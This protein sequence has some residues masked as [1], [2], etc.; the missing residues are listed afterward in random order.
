MVLPAQLNPP[1]FV[2]PLQQV[3][4]TT[5]QVAEGIASS[6]H[7]SLEEKI[8]QF[9]FAEEERTP[10]RPVEILDFEIESDRLS[11]AHQPS[12]AT[13]FFETSSKE[14]K[15]MD[16]EKRPSLRGL[17]ANR[18][19]GA[20]PPEAPKAQASAN[21]PPP[22]PVD[23]GPRVNPDPKKKIPLQELEEGEMPPQKG[24]K[25]QRTKG[26]RDK[27]SKSVESRDDVETH[28]QQC[29]WAPVVEMDEAPIPY[30]STIWES[31]RGHSMYLAQALEQP[32]LL[33]KDMDALRRMRQLDLFM[34]LKRDPAMVS[35][36]SCASQL[37]PLLFTCI[38]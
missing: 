12:Q 23:Q 33:P 1:P 22:L 5:I 4:P 18:G 15:V 14:A 35:V 24:T 25:Q 36:V 2:I 6:S 29:T 21:L 17:M 37:A 16:L 11:I 7:L 10:E 20:T 38:L 9:Q 27:R 28:R 30:E 13:T 8:D 26:P 34:S 19:K 32:F 31:S 3:P